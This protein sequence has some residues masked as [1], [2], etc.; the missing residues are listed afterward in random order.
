MER[1]P[2]VP[3]RADED[4]TDCLTLTSETG[5]STDCGDSS[6][7]RPS[8]SKR[9]SIGQGIMHK[10]HTPPLRRPLA[11]SGAWCS[12]I[13]F[14]RRTRMQL[15]AIESVQSSTRLIHPPASRRSNTQIRRYQTGPG[16]V[17]SRIRIRSADDPGLTRRNLRRLPNLRRG[18][19]QATDRNVP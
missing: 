10:I 13:C 16:M 2:C 4:L 19:P 18:S 8:R 14:R 7:R 6:Y 11:G 9:P 1:G 15:Q 5:F 17:R 3:F 12:A